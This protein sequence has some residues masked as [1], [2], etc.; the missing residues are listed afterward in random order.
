MR[1]HDI[2]IIQ[3]PPSLF[4]LLLVAGFIVVFW[5]WFLLIVGIISVLVLAY[6]LA[7]AVMAR[8]AQQ[9]AMIEA[10]RQRADRQLSGWLSGD[11]RAV[12]GWETNGKEQGS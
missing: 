2:V 4:G 6:F 10:T 5:K 12:F 7:K 1:R 11:E 3:N 9:D 8:R